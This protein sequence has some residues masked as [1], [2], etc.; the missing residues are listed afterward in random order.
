MLFIMS[1]CEVIFSLLHQTKQERK[2]KT[3][4]MS[5]NQ[6]KFSLSDGLETEI[7]FCFSGKK[8]KN[9]LYKCNILNKQIILF[10]VDYLESVVNGDSLLLN[11][12]CETSA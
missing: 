6:K 2:R 10:V 4:C 8:Q 1:R 9:A 7:C 5:N 12:D 3:N 11:L